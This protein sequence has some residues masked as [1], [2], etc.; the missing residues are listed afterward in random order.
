ML[1]GKIWGETRQILQHPMCE[2]HMLGTLAGAK[3]SCHCH[4][5]KYNLFLVVGGEV[6][7]TVIKND[8]ALE[9]TTVLGPG[10]YTIVP[11]GE[12]HWF[13]SVVDSTLL[14]VYYPE[15]IDPK[16]IDRRTVGSGPEKEEN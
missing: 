14:E 1:Q 2:I 9:D 10:D 3:C 7:V 15:A 8:Y 16:D 6:T 4:K 12:Y 11:P 13:E 5:N